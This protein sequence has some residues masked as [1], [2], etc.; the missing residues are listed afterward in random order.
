MLQNF[1]VELELRFG[2]NLQWFHFIF[3]Q[4]ELD[5]FDFFFFVEAA[6]TNLVAEQDMPVYLLPSKILC[7]VIN[8]KLKAD[9]DTDKVFAQ[10]TLLS[11]QIQ[12]ENVVEKEPPVPPR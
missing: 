6:T 2:Q 7:R 1:L 11:E 8:V 5:G 4:F 3:L 10:I 12:D 9:P